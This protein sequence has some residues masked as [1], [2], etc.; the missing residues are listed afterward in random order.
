MYLNAFIYIYIYI[1]GV[2][3][4]IEAFVIIGVKNVLQ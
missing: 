4:F 1:Y 3:V 2:F